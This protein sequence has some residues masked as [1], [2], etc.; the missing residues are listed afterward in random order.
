MTRTNFAAA[1]A[2]MS[3]AGL[4]AGTAGH[5]LAAQD[6]LPAQPFSATSTG[7]GGTDP[8]TFAGFDTSLG[9]LTGV[10]VAL[11]DVTTGETYAVTAMLGAEGGAAQQTDNFLI[12]DASSATLVGSP[13]ENVG[14]SCATLD[15]TSG[16]GSSPSLTLSDFAPNPATPSDLSDYEGA[17]V[18]LTAVITQSLNNTCDTT[19]GGSCDWTNGATF[20]GDLQVTYDYTPND[21][22]GV[23][24]PPSLALL[25]IGLAGLGFAARRQRQAAR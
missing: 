11:Q 18:T 23:P 5:A 25:G 3:G 16:P 1:L 22:T 7:S 2:V 6:V 9:T 15:C 21:V 24:E 8:L 17:N 14:I 4:L 20:A 12:Q 10:E 13:S 19:F